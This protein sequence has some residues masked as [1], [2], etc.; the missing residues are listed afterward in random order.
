MAMLED[1]VGRGESTW[2]IRSAGALVIALLGLGC[3]LGPGPEDP[4]ESSSS[5]STGLSCMPGETRVCACPDGSAGLETCNVLG[6]AFDACDCT[7]T[8]ASTTTASTTEPDGTSTTTD[9]TTSSVDDTAT[10][11]DGTATTGSTDGD[12]TTGEPDAAYGPCIDDVDCMVEG[13]I[14]VGTGGATPNTVCML[15]GCADAGRCPPAPPGA[16]A[17]PECADLTGRGVDECFLACASTEDCPEGMI[18]FTAGASACVWP[19]R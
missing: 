16:A 1:G 19:P 17:T 14:C 7:G 15:Q 8:T 4:S 6:T 2:A 3:P 11:T 12:T 5:G 18:C 9:S 13:E 10:T